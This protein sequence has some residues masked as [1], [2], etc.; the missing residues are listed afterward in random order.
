[1]CGMGCL[2]SLRSDVIIP[3]SYQRML[4]KNH[5]LGLSNNTRPEC[6]CCERVQRGDRVEEVGT[7][8]PADA[9]ID[10]AAWIA[11]DAEADYRSEIILASLARITG[12]H[13]CTL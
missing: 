7:R 10:K 4:P 5:S 13:N 2:M 12:A 11:L 6:L 1:M 8:K 9:D 3:R